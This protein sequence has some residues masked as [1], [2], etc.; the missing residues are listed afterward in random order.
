MVADERRRLGAEDL[1][2]FLELIEEHLD[3]DITLVAA[4]GTALTLL[5]AKPST[6]DIDF[7]GPPDS[8]EAFHDAESREAH[9]YEIDTWPDGTVFSLTLPDDYLARS[10]AVDAG[11]ERI[12]LRTLHPV[13]LIV[14]K[15]AR[16]DERDREDIRTTRERFDVTVEE[17]EQRVSEVAYVGS[18]E[19]YEANLETAIRECFDEA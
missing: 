14:T 5:D 17:V 2:Q 8:L 7:T 18:W 15:I 16:C 12:E 13:D 4:G 1:L 10:Q 3:E 6:I 19:N 9:G 11:L